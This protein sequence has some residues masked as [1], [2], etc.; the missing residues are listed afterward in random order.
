MYALL[1]HPD[2]TAIEATGYP[3]RMQRQAHV[4]PVCE[5]ECDW[6]YTDTLRNPVGCDRCIRREP[7]EEYMGDI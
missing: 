6:I 1:Q 3:T 4:C 5:Q 7:V 2:I